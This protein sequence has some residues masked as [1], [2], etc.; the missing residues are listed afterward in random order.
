MIGKLLL[1]KGQIK[2]V[3]ATEATFDSQF[4]TAL[5]KK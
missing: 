3:P 1:A 5:G 2:A 4:V